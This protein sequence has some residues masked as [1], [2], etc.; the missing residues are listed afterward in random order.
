MEIP[1]QSVVFKLPDLGEGVVEA[2]IVAWHVK[3][4][5]GVQGDQPL[6]AVMADQATATRPSGRGRRG[7]TQRRAADD[8]PG[9]TPRRAGD[10][11][12]CAGGTRAGGHAEDHDHLTAAG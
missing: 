2:E 11:A 1:M 4:G 9:G 3:P 8:R 7:G 5:D 10:R 12:A 6:V